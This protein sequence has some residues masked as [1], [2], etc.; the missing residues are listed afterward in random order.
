MEIRFAVE[1]DA[2]QCNKFYNDYYLL[3][4]TCEQ[5]KWE[6]LE[7][8]QC[9]PLPFVVT[10]ENDEIVA[11]QALIKI[12]LIDEKGV[13]WSA[14]SEETLVSPT[15]RGKKVFEKMYESLFDFAKQE[16]L[17]SI[18]GFTPAVKP[19][20]KVGFDVPLSTKQLI[21]FF[22]PAA[23]FKMEALKSKGI[24]YKTA[25][26]F[27]ALGLV[28]KSNFQKMFLFNGAKK[29]E[30]IR[31]MLSADEVDDSLCRRFIKNWGG[32]TIYRDRLFM[33]WRVFNNPYCECSV[34]GYFVDEKL[35]AFLVYSLDEDQ[36]GYVVDIISAHPGGKEGDVRAIRALLHESSIRLRKEGAHSIRAWSVTDHPFDQLFQSI[37]CKQGFFK[38]NLGSPAVFYTGHDKD[39]RGSSHDDFNSWYVTRI[40]TQGTQG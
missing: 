19:F 15:M 2:V 36:S 1:G 7:Y 40:F 22:H 10:V 4:R 25:A 16:K 26:W 38:V 28:A 14:K 21:K 9:D 37:A 3:T 30:E 18:W 33:D 8:S 29:G 13:F 35:V 34:L 5:W 32:T 20:E 6:F 27:V 17:Y 11:T 12:P 23:T 31:L 39:R 24:I